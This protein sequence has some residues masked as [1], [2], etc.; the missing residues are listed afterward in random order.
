VPHGPDGP[1]QGKKRK[2]LFGI[3]TASGEAKRL[4]W[5]HR[6]PLA[7]GF[8]LMVISRLAGFVLPLSSQVLLDDVISDG[9]PEL[10]VPLALGVAAATI[11]QSLTGFG[12]AKVVS[13][14]AQRAIRNMRKLV[15]AHVLR[16]PVSYYETT[17]SGV[18]ISR[19]MT[20]PEGIRNLVGTGLIHLIGGLFTVAIAF[21]L[22]LQ[23]NW[24]L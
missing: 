17:K 10:L 4:L 7:I 5:E 13:V 20:A 21:V 19:I 22:Q 12:L 16:L 1:D 18:L 24:Q 15:Q 8:V 14:A 23:R 2:G 3:G 6:G 9:R 11:V